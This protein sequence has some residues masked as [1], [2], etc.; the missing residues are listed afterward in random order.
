MAAAAAA[1]SP[2]GHI[3]EI[4]R[5]K[6]SIGGEP[7]PLTEDLHQAVKNLSAELYSKDVHFLMELI[8]NAEDNEY[9]VG[10][11]PTL[12]FVITSKDI[13][14]TGAKATLVIFNNEKGFARQNIESI[15]SVGRS[16]KKGNR[17]N[18][19][20][21]EKGIGFKSVFLITSQPYIFSKGYQIRFSEEPCSQCKIGY[22]VPEWVENENPVL[23]HIRQIYGS[24]TSLP[25]TTMVLPLKSDKVDPV[26]KQLSKI[27]PELLLFLSKIRKL[28]V[29]EDNADRKLNTVSTISISSEKNLVT[30]KNINAESYALILSSDEDKGN[31]QCSY[32]M[33]RQ[34]FPVKNGCRVDRRMDV[35]DWVITI[36]F[37]HGERLNRGN[38]SPGI[39]AFLP[40]EMVTNFPFII[41]ADFLLSSSRETILLD[42]QWNKGILDCVPLVFL[43]AFTSLV[44]ASD[45]VPVSSLAEMFRFLPVESSSYPS[46]DATVRDPIKAKLQ[47]EDIVPCQ[48][49]TNQKVFR[50]PC[51]VGRLLPAF[52]NLLKEATKQGVTFHNISSHGKS[53]LNSAFDKEKYN[54]VLNFLEVK[55]VEHDWYAKCI[56]GSNLVMGV[57]EELYVQLL[58]FVSANWR[59]AFSKTNMGKL[60]LLKYVDSNEH[61]ALCS[62]DSV[63]GRQITLFLCTKSNH[64]SWLISW[65][66]VFRCMEGY[67]FP[68]STHKVFNDSSAVWK[69]ISE[70]MM[71]DVK[72]RSVDTDE[73]AQVI[74]QS[75]SHDRKLVLAY[76]HFL[77]HSYMKD[78]VVSASD[79]KSQC[80]NMPL[81]DDYGKVWTQRQGVLVPANG[82][83]WVQLIG[84]NPWKREGYIEL[85]EEYLHSQR[86]VANVYA[87]NGDI[88]GFLKDYA[89]AMDI[90]ELPPPDATLS[91]MSSPLTKENAFLLLD[92]IRN[93]GV[94][95]GK[96]LSSIKN[97][98]WL[99]VRLC[100]STGYRPPSQSFF[101]DSK[102]GP[103][104]QN[105][106]LR[107]DI[108][109]VD[110]AFYGSQISDYKE[111]LRTTGVMFELK[112]ACEFIGKHFMS[113]VDSSSFANHDVISILK[114]IKYLREKYLPPGDFINSIKDKSWLR[115]TQGMKKPG[116]CVFLADKWS[117]I[118]QISN[119]PFV[120]QKLYGQDILIFKE[121]LRLLGV[122]F[123]FNKNYNLVVSNLKPSEHL[124]SLSAKTAFLALKCI[125]HLKLNSTD[126]L[127][128]ALKGNR[129][130]KTSA[131]GYKS[132]TECFL[133]DAT[134]S[135]ILHVFD[136]FPIIDEKFYGS[137]IFSFKDEL[138]NLGVVVSFEGVVKTFVEV[139]KQQSSKCALSKTCALSFLACYRKLKATAFSSQFDEILKNIKDVKWL[140]T[141]LG[142]ASAP[143]ECILFDESWAPISSISLLPFV[144]D[145]YY[146][147]E[148]R[149]YKVE[150]NAMGV[151]TTFR[152]GAVF[153]PASLR[154][155]QNPDV[156]SPPVAL[157]LFMCVQN[158]QKNHDKNHPDLLSS[159][160]EKLNVQWIKTR[161]GYRCPKDCL[162][163]SPEWKDVLNQDDG[164][165]IDE[166]FYGPE[167]ASYS[168]DLQTLGVVVEV[169][170]GCSLVAEYL[171]VHSDKTSISR[172]YKYLDKNGWHGDLIS[173]K[174][175]K[176]IWIPSG[177]S[178]GKWVSPQTCIL[179]DRTGLFVPEFFVLE[180]YYSNELLH[181][182]SKV[183]VKTYPALEDFF[184]LWKSWEGSSERKLSQSECCAFWEFIVTHWSSK[185]KKFL[186]D[187]LKKIPA[188]SVANEGIYLLDKC[189]VF[190]ADDHYMKDLFEQNSSDPLF[191]WYP[192]PS[193][194]SLPRTKLLDIYKEIG[195]GYLS[196]S[197]KN[198]GISSIE[199]SG[200]ERVKPETIHIGM[201][202][203]TL[204]L[205]F[206]AQPSLEMDA[207]ERHKSLMSLVDSSFLKMDE[208]ITFDYSLSLSSGK[209]LTAKASRMIRWER[210][211]SKFFITEL[212][213]SEGYRGVL[214]YATCFS[215][216]ISEGILWDKE[217]HVPQLSELIKLGYLVKFDKD[218]ISFL[219]KTKNLQVF[220]EDEQFLSSLFHSC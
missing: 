33:W 205:G 186:E 135:C 27:H 206:L 184:K 122:I 40:T 153:V 200:L 87:K 97:G 124:N 58:L 198:N 139:F 136:N 2:K 158:L 57:S 18:G 60:P 163:F 142:A 54:N 197:V 148:I 79:I 74:R 75:L 118:S 202:L 61:V 128:I 157:S 105:G 218:A 191:V 119:V 127:C 37:P 210:E 113:L 134:W 98:S 52:W 68:E 5:C 109:L 132:A 45:D 170:D 182:F 162:L 166:K 116:Q 111:A 11:N 144:D 117:A 204:I 190:L 146:G 106:S 46:L 176:M 183:G 9:E 154:L 159:L 30:R 22:I 42:N 85:G 211:S 216:V 82:S 65:N 24:S 199:S 93:R 36:A 143:E 112:E 219:M 178:S 195:V 164:P 70:W 179:H 14:E 94:L 114:F 28:S 192:Q 32:H 26:K 6:F 91:C 17:K 129:C 108:P 92:W 3:E 107:V 123:E 19:Y 165:F 31:G 174:N 201:N 120:D 115:T 77:Y 214:E 62:T 86:Y 34:R 140:K 181:F 51:Q 76:A 217:D 188:F 172:I 29:R 104:L 35:E 43:S 81:V 99:R 121:E 126:R 137:K 103:H 69:N 20:I 173:N 7:N 196:K 130:L 95:P 96:F 189:D 160:R 55:N 73:Y 220:L 141:R 38:S 72:V 88:L 53:I 78:Y 185:T 13:T 4:R 50:K 171:N 101:P 90:P 25:T 161:A 149:D 131:N 187:N 208:P 80:I 133:P 145:A 64:V 100:G 59:S 83:K 138:K 125:R 152:K 48:S 150:L 15:C 194:P 12:E 10:V 209:I 177:D 84:T 168:K 56:Q 39:Y 193:L 175:S 67:F 8:Q 102:W 167:I 151:A 89:G 212:E 180:K 16:T 110:L 155:P 169:K 21:G 63:S 156:I 207:E 203:F 47:E 215:E 147:P 66:K 1:L 41:Q 23:A 49:F 213:E 44:K 71:N